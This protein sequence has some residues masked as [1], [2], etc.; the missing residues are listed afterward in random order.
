MNSPTYAQIAGNFGLWEEYVDRSGHMTEE[1]FDEM[2]ISERMDF[3]VG[4]FGREERE[5]E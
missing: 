2:T 4:C 1:Q 3:I 5:T